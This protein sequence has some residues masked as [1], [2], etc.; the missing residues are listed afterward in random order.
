[1]KPLLLITGLVICFLT[2][3]AQEITFTPL[4]L[5][6]P[7]Y[8]EPY[9]NSTHGLMHINGSSLYVP[10]SHG[11]YSIN[12]SAQENG[13][14]LEG[15]ENEPIIEFVR[16]GD[17]WLAITRHQGSNLLLYSADQGKTYTDVTPYKLFPE[18]KYNN[19][20]RLCQDPH[21]TDII[22][23]GTAYTGLMKSEDFGKTWK[24]LTE[25][26]FSNP[27]YS[28]LEVH[29][30]DSN[31]LLQHGESNALSPHIQ[32]SYNQGQNWINTSGYP[33][34]D[35]TLP[36]EVTAM[37]NCIHDVAFHPTDINTWIFGGEGIICKS[38]DRGKT[39]ELKKTG[40]HNATLGYQYC[41]LFDTANHDTV[42]SLGISDSKTAPSSRT[43]YSFMIS[44]DCGET[45]Q[46][47]LK[48][49]DGGHQTYHDMVQDDKQLIILA[50]DDVYLVKKDK[51]LTHASTANVG[52]DN[53]LPDGDIYSI[54]GILI[55]RNANETDLMNLPAGI[56]IY[57]GEKTR[58][59]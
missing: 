39:W 16:K 47:A 38:T 57:K 46:S 8:S 35:I 36:Y 33:T 28:G 15:F 2:A 7:P 1:M 44:T 58:I 34:P 23:L 3:N 4:G 18:S 42:Y 10:T 11:I 53:N 43:L 20:T 26:W 37:D 49:R 13:W 29:P 32:I 55:M 52:I 56:Y 30:L 22:Y 51:L 21:N 12:L 41:T 17:E 45:W 6:Y 14:K 19:V 24:L 5:P 50:D 48:E 59:K 9:H 54:E 31:I 27:T 40:W 25:I